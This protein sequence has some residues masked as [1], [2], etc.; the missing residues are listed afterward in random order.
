MTH[1]AHFLAHQ[2]KAHNY[3]TK[4]DTKL[5]LVVSCGNKTFKYLLG[6]VR[7]NA[8]YISHIA[9]IKLCRCCWHMG[10]GGPAWTSSEDI[11]LK[12][13]GKLVYRCVRIMSLGVRWFASRAL[14]GDNS[15][16]E[17]RHRDYYLHS[18]I[19]LKEIVGMG[20]NGGIHSQVTGPVFRQEWKSWHPMLFLSTATLS[21]YS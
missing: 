16:A 11:S 17:R 18:I 4:F 5:K 21:C 1:Y 3:T 15:P 14:L 19:Y 12:Y 13:Y 6:N 9:V 8:T 2:H 20:F 7:K 10:W